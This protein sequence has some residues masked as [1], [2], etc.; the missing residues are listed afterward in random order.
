MAWCKPIINA[1]K[2]VDDLAG[3]VDD[4]EEAD[5]VAALADVLDEFGCLHSRKRRGGQE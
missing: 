2:S 4:A 5:A 3:G 1:N